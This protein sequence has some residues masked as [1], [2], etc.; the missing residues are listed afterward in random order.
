M[1]FESVSNHQ[2]IPLIFKDINLPLI[3]VISELLGLTG[4]IL[5]CDAHTLVTTY[6]KLFQKARPP[7]KQTFFTPP[8]TEG[9]HWPRFC[10]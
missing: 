2:A 3:K 10:T 1:G 8:Q 5:G 4:T 6:H 9:L 7:R